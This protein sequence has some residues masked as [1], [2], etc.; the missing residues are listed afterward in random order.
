MLLL[1]FEVKFFWLFRFLVILLLKVSQLLLCRFFSRCG[2]YL[3]MFVA[4][5]IVVCFKA[6]LVG[7]NYVL[8]NLK[9]IIEYH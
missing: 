2:N 9:I 1:G 3:G 5:R 7:A 4:V 8:Y 6:V